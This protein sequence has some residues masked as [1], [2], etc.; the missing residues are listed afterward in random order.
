MKASAT[1]RLQLEANLVPELKRRG[2]RILIGGDY[3]FPFNPHGRNARD[4]QH[5]VDYYGFTPAEA[6]SAATMLGGQLMGQQVGLI[7]EN[8]LAD[9]LLVKG[10][11]TQDIAILQ[12]PARLTVIMQGGRLHKAPAAQPVSA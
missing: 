7:R 9:L 4:L 8:Y 2:V 1:Q 3:G 12:D 10:D 11:P 5:F 6:L